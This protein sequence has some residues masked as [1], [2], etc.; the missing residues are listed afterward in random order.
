MSFPPH[1]YLGN[2]ITLRTFLAKIHLGAN[3]PIINNL[4]YIKLYTVQASNSCTSQLD[5]SQCLV[6]QTPL[7]NMSRNKPSTPMIHVGCE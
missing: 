2:I 1:Q 4:Y 7:D 5:V 3:K 6:V